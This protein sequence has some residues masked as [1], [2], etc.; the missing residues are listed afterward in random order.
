MKIY[1]FS[2]TYDAV[3]MTSLGIR[4][5]LKDYKGK[6]DA[7]M[8]CV[9]IFGK[10]IDLTNENMKPMKAVPGKDR[11]LVAKGH[12]ETATCGMRTGVRA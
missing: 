7:Y 3:Y 9:D 8:W 2:G 12:I 5:Q 11:L 6:A 4:Q 10:Y 1:S